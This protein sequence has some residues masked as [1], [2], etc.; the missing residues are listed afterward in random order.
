VAGKIAWGL[1]MHDSERGVAHVASLTTMKFFKA[2]LSS[3]TT[4]LL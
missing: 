4:E 1:L 3:A 2:K